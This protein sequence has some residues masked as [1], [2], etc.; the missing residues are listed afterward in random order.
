[1]TTN[2]VLM[3]ESKEVLELSEKLGFSKTLF[4]KDVVLVRE[5]RKKEVLKK[6]NEGKKKGLLV[7][8]EVASEDILRFVLERTSADIVL[9]QEM[10]NPDDSVH[11]RRGGL[12][13]I[14]CKIAAKKGKA[15]GFSFR[16]ILESKDRSKL[17]GRMMFNVKLCKKYGV[18]MVFS[19]FSEGIKEMRGKHELKAFERILRF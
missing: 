5:K 18:K 15:V 1:M 2:I 8:V 4:L 10:I 13:Q 12:D 11:F 7:I 6:V 3:K 16:E 17:L 9:G 14:I 19:N